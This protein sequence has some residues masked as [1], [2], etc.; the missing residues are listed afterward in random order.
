MA[1]CAHHSASMS[2][3]IDGPNAISTR[4]PTGKATSVM[5]RTVVVPSRSG[6]SL[7]RR[8]RVTTDSDPSDASTAPATARNPLPSAPRDG[9]RNN[10]VETIGLAMLNSLATCSGSMP[11]PSSST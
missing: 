11:G 3:G 1:N 2:A 8:L 7:I 10:L 6:C 9:R 5:S 4:V